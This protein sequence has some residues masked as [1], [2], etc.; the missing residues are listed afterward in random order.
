MLQILVWKCPETGKLF[1]EQS[2]YKKHLNKLAQERRAVKRQNYIKNTFFDWLDNE[3]TNVVLDINDIPQWLLDNQQT[4]MDAVNAMPNIITASFGDK[5]KKGDLFT[6]IEFDRAN[7]NSNLSNS[8]LCPKGGVK[9]WGGKGTFADG[10]PKPTG[11]P[12]WQLNI[13]GTLQRNKKN[14]CSYPYDGLFNAVGVHTGSG[15]GG[16]ENF[17]YDAKIFAAEWPGAASARTFAKLVS[18]I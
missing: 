8:H 18:N 9:N 10:T 5:F 3:R 4:I 1:E 7:W 17:G 13:R 11:Y 2:D 16:N 6:K 15:G 14:M 12:G